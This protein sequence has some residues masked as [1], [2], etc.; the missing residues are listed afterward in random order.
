MIV[1]ERNDWEP[2]ERYYFRSTRGLTPICELA[3][4]GDGWEVLFYRGAS[5]PGPHPYA[6]FDHAKAHIMRFLATR[7][8][9]LRGPEAVWATA[10]ANPT[11]TPAG[12]LQTRHPRRARRRSS[13]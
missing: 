9:E 8:D 10:N 4:Q 7:E 3:R 12:N 6:S 11:A 1:Y 5:R 13:L 2:V